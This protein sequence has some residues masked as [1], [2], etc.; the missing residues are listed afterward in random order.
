MSLRGKFPMS[1]KP[2]LEVQNLVKHFDATSNGE[3]SRAKRT[4]HAVQHISDRVAVMYLGKIVELAKT[5]ELYTKSQHPYTRALLSAIPIPDPV[6][7][8]SRQQILLKGDIPSA[9][10]PPSGCVFNTR[11]W[12]A[13]PK[14]FSEEPKLVKSGAS[15]VACHFPE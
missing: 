12:K 7:E 1:N 14:C 15:E 6:Q 5:S 13:Q 2:L 4:I 3:C 10:N 8:R 11:C 9:A